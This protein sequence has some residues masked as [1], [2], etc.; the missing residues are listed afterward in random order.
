MWVWDIGHEGKS[1]FE[2]V[3]VQ[4]QRG[5][6]PQKCILPLL[7]GAQW[8]TLRTHLLLEIAAYNAKT[9]KKGLEKSWQS[10]FAIAAVTPFGALFCNHL[11]NHCQKSFMQGCLLLRVPMREMRIFANRRRPCDWQGQNQHELLG[12]YSQINTSLHFPSI[13]RNFDQSEFDKAILIAQ[14]RTPSCKR[15]FRNQ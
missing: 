4:R 1:D 12:F 14:L 7:Q 5:E 10:N 13:G 15:G 11:F 3:T 2:R 9:Q 6:K 8:K